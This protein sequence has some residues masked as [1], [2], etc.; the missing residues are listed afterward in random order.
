MHRGYY[1]LVPVLNYLT[2]ILQDVFVSN[3]TSVYAN[4]RRGQLNG[5]YVQISSNASQIPYA[6]L[7]Y[8]NAYL[9][10]GAY[11]LTFHSVFLSALLSVCVSVCN[12]AD[13]LDQIPKSVS[14][15]GK[16]WRLSILS[17][18]PKLC[19]IKLSWSAA[20][21]AKCFGTAHIKFGNR[22]T[23]IVC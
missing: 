14:I 18:D 12:C 3:D 9:L 1:E 13:L 8:P 19:G 11:K 2:G 15:R 5:T 23:V 10:V 20:C 22:S 17:S 6:T 21:N 4:Q 7:K 16:R